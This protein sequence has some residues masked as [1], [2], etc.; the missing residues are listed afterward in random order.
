MWDQ[1]LGKIWK[2]L[3][4]VT[5]AAEKELK[6]KYQSL[7]TWRPLQSDPAELFSIES[8]L[9]PQA[10]LLKK[11]AFP[12]FL[13]CL[14]CKVKWWDLQKKSAAWGHEAKREGSWSESP[15]I[16]LPSLHLSV[17]YFPSKFFF[18]LCF[19]LNAA[20]SPCWSCV[21]KIWHWHSYWHSIWHL[22]RQYHR[23]PMLLLLLSNP[24]L[25]F[26]QV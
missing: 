14:L 16:P 23:T 5:C 11:S 19:P 18:L 20:P 6:E 12:L 22:S 1:R 9:W 15:S 13:Q 4:S 24:K 7:R 21:V 26:S 25:G 10:H 17:H 2:P 8:E 3:C